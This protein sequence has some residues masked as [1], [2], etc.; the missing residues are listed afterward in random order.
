[1]NQRL[2][3]MTARRG[4]GVDEGDDMSETTNRQVRS[5]CER[6]FSVICS[7]DTWPIIDDC[8]DALYRMGLSA[9]EIAM[10]LRVAANREYVEEP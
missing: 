1:M 2:K 9:P 6:M 3:T 5:D 4:S 8:V 7:H 10:A